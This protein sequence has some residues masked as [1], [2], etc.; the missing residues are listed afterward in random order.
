M[1]QLPEI[2]DQQ[3][4]EA[5]DP[6]EIRAAF[7]NIRGAINTGLESDNIKDGAVTDAKVGNRTVDDATATAYGNTGPLTQILSWFAKQLKAIVGGAAWS[8]TPPTTLTAAKAHIDAVA[9]HSGHETPAGAQAKASAAQT[10]AQGYADSAVATHEADTSTHGVTGAIVGTTDVQVLSNKSL[11][12]DLAAGG[13]KITGL[14]APTE[15]G[16]ATNRS[17]VSTYM[18]AVM[19]PHINSASH[20][21]HYN[22]KTLN[23]ITLYVRTDGNNSNDGSANDAAHALLTIQ[24]A[25]D[26]LPKIINHAAS[27]MVEAGTYNE[28]VLIRGFTGFG[29]LTVMGSAL[30]H[31]ETHN[32]ISITCTNNG[33]LVDTIGFTLTKAESDFV[34]YRC[35]HIRLSYCRTISSSV[36]TAAALTFSYCGVELVSCVIS[37]KAGQNQP[38]IEANFGAHVYVDGCSGTGNSVGVRALRGG[39]IAIKGNI[40]TATTAKVIASGG[41]IINEDGSLFIPS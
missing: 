1:S 11:G 4:G 17:F 23:N 24:A 29:T 34:A 37:N 31:P 35:L 20:D 15:D 14:G 6:D 3:V 9:P 19:T 32:V 7:N 33:I 12:T 41:M 25:I 26:K 22:S 8:T 18:N 27:I 28:N 30:Y 2:F 13:K 39:R 16:D 10:A 5:A 21:S 36:S 40:P 38:T